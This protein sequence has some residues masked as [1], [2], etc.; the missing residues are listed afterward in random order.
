MAFIEVT[1]IMINELP[2][3]FAKEDLHTIFPNEQTEIVR[4]NLIPDRFK[5]DKCLGFIEFR[6][7]DPIKRICPN[8]LPRPML[9]GT[10]RLTARPA[11][12]S[13]QQQEKI[14]MLLKTH[15]LCRASSQ[16]SHRQK[17]VHRMRMK[18]KWWPVNSQKQILQ[19]A[20]RQQTITLK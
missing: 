4:V 2:A 6:T 14:K 19:A 20:V 13:S 9:F 8:G 17:N 3:D 7:P 15:L 18:T 10:L 16:Q 11:K 12:I 5:A 1:T